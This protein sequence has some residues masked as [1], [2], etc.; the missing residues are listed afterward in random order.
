[1]FKKILCFLLFFIVACKDKNKQQLSPQLKNDEQSVVR[2]FDAT[3]TQKISRTDSLQKVISNIDSLAVTAPSVIVMR[4]II[5]A[6]FSRRSGHFTAAEVYFRRARELH[7]NRDSLSFYIFYGL[8]STYKSI[9]N[10]PEGVRNLYQAVAIGEQLKDTL[11]ITQAYSSLSQLQAEKGDMSAARI[12]VNKI[13]SI[14]Q[15]KTYLPPYL[16]AMHTLANIEGQTGNINEAMK[17]DFRGIALADSIGDQMS[18]VM[19]QDNLARCYLMQK[20]YNKARYYF[21]NNQQIEKPFN[22]PGWNADTE[23]NLAE[24][25]TNDGNY[26]LAENHL[27]KAVEIFSE[28]CR[29]QERLFSLA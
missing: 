24:V 16:N 5:K 18:K 12:T 13:F 19:F 20:N 14:L 4:E 25:E 27:N 21:N 2:L 26:A 10:F 15:D 29:I 17:L 1:M 3:V 6:N 23:I 22:N 9:G 7:N 28:N 8:G 11:K